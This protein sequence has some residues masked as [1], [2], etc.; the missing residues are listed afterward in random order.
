[1][2]RCL[3]LGA[4]AKPKASAKREEWWNLDL[5]APAHVDP[6]V[7]IIKGSILALTDIFQAGWFDHVESEFCFEHLTPHEILDTLWQVH[8]ILKPKGTMRV[9]VPDF[10]YLTGK[11]DEAA[12]RG[13]LSFEDVAL[14]HLR[15]FGEERTTIHRSIWTPLSGLYY[16]RMESLF[17]VVLTQQG[18][19][20]HLTY[21]CHRNGS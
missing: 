9:R 11:Y 10:A 12:S 21:M 7:K 6:K 18:P 15:V 14:V 19:N 16:L 1:M 8:Q 2:K 4:G 20:D 3:Q 13:P 17:R 5:S